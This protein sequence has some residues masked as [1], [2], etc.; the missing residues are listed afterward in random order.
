MYGANQLGQA[1]GTVL[2]LLTPWI[3]VLAVAFSVALGT[4][5]GAL[6]AWN[7]SGFDPIEALRYE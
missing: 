1:S 3:A 4:L 2:F 5:A 6:P 7:A